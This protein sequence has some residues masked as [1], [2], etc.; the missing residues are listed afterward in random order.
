MRPTI[1]LDSAKGTI[2]FTDEAYNLDPA[3]SNSFG[4]EVLDVILEKIE[5][6][7]GSDM[8]VILAGYKPQMDQL[9]R[10]VQN[11]GL[12]RRFNLGESFNF[13]DFSDNEIR[14]VLKKQI[15]CKLF[16]CRCTYFGSCHK[17]D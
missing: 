8:C 9:F 6:N 4:A 15:A 3:R 17:I 13:E 5:A 1:V 7:A 2:L 10:N 14:E 12:K 16:V 11:P